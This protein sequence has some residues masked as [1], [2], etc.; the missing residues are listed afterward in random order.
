M[1]TIIV[2]KKSG[3]GSDLTWKK[4]FEVECNLHDADTTISVLHNLYEKFSHRVL[5]VSEHE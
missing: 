2:E 5:I 3:Y 4:I 1:Y